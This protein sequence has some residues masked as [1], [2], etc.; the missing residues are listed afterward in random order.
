MAGNRASHFLSEVQS[1]SQPSFLGSQIRN[2]KETL[3]HGWYVVKNPDVAAG[4]QAPNLEETRAQEADY[5]RGFLEDKYWSDL[6]RGHDH[7][8]GIFHLTVKLSEVLAV[9][10][11][12]S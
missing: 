12:K 11:R 6:G 5:F 8:L 10:N 2:E 9:L 3:Y 1:F 7:R 4:S